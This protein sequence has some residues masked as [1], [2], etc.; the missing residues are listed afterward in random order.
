[1]MRQVLRAVLSIVLVLLVPAL[2]EARE[3]IAIER[4][5]VV[6]MVPGRAPEADRTVLVRDGRIA[7]IGPSARVRV[8]ASAVRVDGRGRYLIPG[9]TEAHAHPENAPMVRALL[10]MPDLADDAFPTQDVYLPYVAHGITQLLNMSANTDS[11]RQRDEIRAGRVIGP[12]LFNAIMVDGE[13]PLWPFAVQAATPEAGRA[14]VRRVAGQGFEFIKVYSQL[15]AETLA[16]VAD[17]AARHNL[18]VIGHIPGRGRNDTARYLPANFAMAAHAEEF[19]FQAPDLAT[20]EASIPDYVRLMRARGIWVTATLTLDDRILEQVRHPAA[21]AQR[22]ELRFLNLATRV[23]WLHGN[24]YANREPEFTGFMEQLTAF[25]RRLVKAMHE[26]GVP[27]L[28]GTDAVVPGVMPGA[29]LHDELEALVGAGLSPQAALDSAT[30]LPAVFLGVAGDRGTI[31]RG[32]RADLVL[33]DGDPLAAI[34][35]TRRIAGVLVSGRYLSRQ[36]LDARMEDLAMRNA[37]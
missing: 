36:D 25:N 24:P 5:T 15:D 18:R 28:A 17:E 21:L 11:V 22:P 33:L 2:A 16:A 7:R 29:S 1:M 9:L 23:F 34:S 8:P 6:S 12:H 13:P 31:E 4:V 19:A 20:A 10:R 32:K 26:G 37:R 35:N 14:F 30:R 3:V 27:I